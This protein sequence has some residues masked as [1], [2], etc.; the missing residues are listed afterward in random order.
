MTITVSRYYRETGISIV[1]FFNIKGKM[2]NGA[3]WAPSS[4][5]QKK[6]ILSIVLKICIVSYCYLDIIYQGLVS[7]CDVI[8][9]GTVKLILDD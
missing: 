2:H 3:T 6:S 4:G 8:Y 1:F 7:I 9:D 5:L